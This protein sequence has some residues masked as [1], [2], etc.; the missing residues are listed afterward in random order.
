MTRMTDDSAWAIIEPTR[1]ALQRLLDGVGNRDDA[2]LVG[3]G[4]NMAWLRIRRLSALRKPDLHRLE[5]AIRQLEELC[6]L[7][8]PP[9]K[10]SPE[11]HF[12]LC[13][14]INLYDRCCRRSSIPE[15][16]VAERE[17]FANAKRGEL[18]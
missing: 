2:G 13:V 17:L 14:A 10:P 5:A 6:D 1:C 12:D 3:V 18:V 4:Y 7:D 9:P 15:W 8:N 16:A 11:A